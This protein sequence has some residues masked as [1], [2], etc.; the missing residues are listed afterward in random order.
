MAEVA[1]DVLHN[2]GNVLNSV[3]VSC[4]ITIDRVKGLKAVSLAKVAALLEEN[5]DKL[6]EFLTSDPRG[7]QIPGYLN[8]LSQNTVADQ[9]ALLKELEQL[10]KHIDHIKQIVAMQ[11]NYAKVAGVR[12][13]INPIQLVEDAL[14][15]NAAALNRHVVKVCREFENLPAISTE[16]HKVM[17][18]LVNLI[19]NAKYAL[20][21]SKQQEKLLTLKVGSDGN[22]AVKID[23]IDNGVGIARENLTR[24]FR[25]GFTTRANGHGFGLHS[26]AL[27]VRE[28]GGSL[29]AYSDGLGKGAR[30]TLLLPYKTLNQSE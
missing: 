7:Q 21:E 5:R 1:T 29:L 28:L 2:V 24:I 10:L 15:I 13:M 30:F 23:V 6:A 8:A 25:H 19:R 17:Q 20:D 4:S 9:T 27:A 22:G 14:H 3:N 16:K 12:E 26:S 11:Q 18:I